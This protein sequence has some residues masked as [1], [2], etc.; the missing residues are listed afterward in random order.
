MPARSPPSLSLC[1]QKYYQPLALLA[2]S[3]KPVLRA[4]E[5]KAL[6]SNLGA[7]IAVHT[8][9]LEGLAARI[10]A[11]TPQTLLGDLFISAVRVTSPHPITHCA[12][13]LPM[14]KVYTEYVNNFDHSIALLAQLKREN[15]AFAAFLAVR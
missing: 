13:Q 15:S 3:K 7:I 4:P 11:W 8:M 6:F 1:A 10:T 12:M 2:E 14:L 5:L 9:L